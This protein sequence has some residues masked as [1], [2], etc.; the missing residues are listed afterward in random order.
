MSNQ[1]QDSQVNRKRRF[2]LV[3]PVLI[4]P[5]L[6]LFFWAMGGGTSNKVNATENNK[7]GFNSVLPGANLKSEEGL[8]KMSFYEQA[9]KDSAQMRAQIKKDPNVQQADIAPQ[10]ME[11]SSFASPS[12]GYTGLRT[13]PYSGAG[14]NDP[15][16]AKIYQRLEQLNQALSQ[17]QT[18]PTDEQRLGFSGGK[19]L[20]DKDVDRLE[21][22]MQQMKSGSGE[23]DPE[24]DQLHGMLDKIIEIQNPE[25]AQQKL[26][27]MS[28]KNKGQV[29]A[30]TTGKKKE[31]YS[32]LEQTSSA[33][34]PDASNGKSDNNGF[35]ALDLATDMDHDQNAIDAVIHETQ[36]LVSG[37]TV[38]LR[39]LNDIYINGKLIPKDNFVFGTAALNGERLSIKI[40]GIRYKKS[41]FPVGLAVIDIDGL[42]GVYIP[43]AISRDVAKQSSDRAIQ[44]LSF[45]TMSNNI[46]VQA[47]GAG[48]EA[49][50]SLFSKKVKLIK[51][52]VKAG[53]KVLLKD[54]RQRLEN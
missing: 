24:M 9:M 46:G 43:G 41:I 28:E 10:L 17:Q 32:L 34:S 39:L 50:K 14:Y 36:T 44:D 1:Q 22:L 49:A 37:S 54:E 11:Y 7:K 40:S 21:R 31:I 26:K 8:D 48:L 19:S 52:T 30:V 23:A 47:A 35:F 25:L 33:N 13:S 16:E 2:Q 42:E 4:L 6:T 18:Q 29:Y 12:G 5:F 27:D 51:V 20:D 38:K 15:N 53:Y 45:G 3:L